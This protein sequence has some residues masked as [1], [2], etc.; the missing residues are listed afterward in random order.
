MCSKW[1]KG[2]RK[3]NK[4]QLKKVHE[5]LKGKHIKTVEDILKGE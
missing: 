5:F 1:L 4:E 3:L 2:E